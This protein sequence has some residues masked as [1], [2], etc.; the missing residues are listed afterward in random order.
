MPDTTLS[1]NSKVT[2]IVVCS[3]KVY[4]DLEAAREGVNDV[5]GIR[6]EPFYP[7]PGRALDDLIAGYPA[8]P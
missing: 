7:L 5:A 1:D 8:A 3:G 4:D 2:R 6:G